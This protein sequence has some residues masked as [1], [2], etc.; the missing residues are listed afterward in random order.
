MEGVT[1]TVRHGV[2]GEQMSEVQSSSDQQFILADPA[3]ESTHSFEVV[4]TR[5]GQPLDTAQTSVEIA[6]AVEEEEPE[7]E[8]EE[9]EEIDEDLVDEE[10]STSLKMAILTHQTNHPHQ[11]TTM[12]PVMVMMVMATIVMMTNQTIHLNH[13]KMMIQTMIMTNKS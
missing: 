8:E 3:R 4:A 12:S 2:N 11:Q 10:D 5:N 13:Q 9:E 1:F 6:E 7:E